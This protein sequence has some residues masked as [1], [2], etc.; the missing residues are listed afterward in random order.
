MFHLP[1]MGS[2][3][4]E[5]PTILLEEP[6]CHWAPRRVRLSLVT[7]NP[8]RKTMIRKFKITE[9]VEGRRVGGIDFVLCDFDLRTVRRSPGFKYLTPHQLTQLSV[10][11]PGNFQSWASVA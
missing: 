10:Q 6:R 4:Q 8:V 11:P 1:S 5:T 7:D 3:K 9:V 2:Q